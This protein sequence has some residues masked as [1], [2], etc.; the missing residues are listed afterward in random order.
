MTKKIPAN[1]LHVSV[2]EWLTSSYLFSFADYYDPD[3][4]SW[5]KLRVWNDDTISP[6]S[7]FPYHSHANFEI[8]TIVFEG[9]L[10]HSD[11]LGNARVLKRGYVQ[12]M[13]AGTGI[14]HAEY[15][16]ALEPLSLYQIWIA[17][18]KKNIEPLYQEREVGFGKKGLHTLISNEH[19]F[20]N[21]PNTALSINADAKILYGNLGEGNAENYALK[22]DD[23]A[24]IYV[25]SG[26]LVIGHNDLKAGDQLR[27]HDEEK[28]FI[29]AKEDTEFVMVVTW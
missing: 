28:L 16:N 2:T 20:E 25:R 29:Q 6:E 17:P 19:F 7:G 8:V 4:M 14:T 24:F 22:K 1:K 13:S 27:I 15:N 18:K 10:S 26:H 11:S 21:A 9:E 5:G 3:N 12:H 23:Y